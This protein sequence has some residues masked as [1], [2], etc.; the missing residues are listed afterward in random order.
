MILPPRITIKPT[1]RP[2]ISQGKMP[3]RKRR[4]F[5]FESDLSIFHL[6]LLGLNVYHLN[7]F[8]YS[9]CFPLLQRGIEGDFS[10]AARIY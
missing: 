10:N 8:G 9:D 7:K 5:V 3:H 4:T 6:P 1:I 2:T